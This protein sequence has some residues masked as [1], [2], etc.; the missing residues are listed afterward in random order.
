MK[1]APLLLCLA[2][3]ATASGACGSCSDRKPD[4]GVAPRAAASAAASGSASAALVAEV[5]PRCRADGARAVIE[6]DDVVV[7]TASLSP[8]G[9][10]VGLVRRVD[11]KRVGSVLRTSV[12]LGSVTIF[13]VGPSVGDD[14]PPSPRWKGGTPHLAYLVRKVVDGG[15]TRGGRELRFATIEDEGVVVL[16]QTV[17]QQADESA[18]YD[19]AWPLVAWDEDALVGQGKLLP[20]HG[21]V[22]IQML[23]DGKPRTVSPPSSDAEGPRLAKRKGGGWWALWLA[24]QPEIE[25][26]GW[27]LEGA[28]DLRTWRWVEIVALDELGVPTSAV[29]RLSSERG[30]AVAFD[31]ASADPELIVMVQDESETRE[32]GGSRLVRYV[33]GADRIASADA[34]DASLGQAL[35]EVVAAE[36]AGWLAFR[37]TSDHAWIAPASAD[38]LV[39]GTPTAEAAL[40]GAR[41]LA[42]SGPSTIYVTAGNELRRFTCSR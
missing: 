35:A 21:V 17:P 40:D 14:P 32:G 7:G 8:S 42:A 20:S 15:A 10:L 31:I 12:D 37:D 1:R 26:A 27:R 22:R 13:D 18:A 28:G 41:V 29:R 16:S 34:A 19:V 33:V 23:P 36:D 6:G 24:Q 38:G 25:D 39:L 30:H 5:L 2:S 9:L 3:V 4:D 11:G